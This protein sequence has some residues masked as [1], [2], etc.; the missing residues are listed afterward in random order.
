VD[1]S[2]TRSSITIGTD[3][4]PVISYNGPVGLTVAHCADTAC[5]AGNTLTSLDSSNSFAI[6][7]TIG[8]D[9]MP[10][11]SY[12]TNPVGSRNL[13]VAHCGNVACSSSG[14]TKTMVDSASMLDSTSIAIGTDGLPVIS[15]STG[16]AS[17]GPLQIAHCGS[18]MCIS[19]WV[20]R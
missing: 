17:G 19:D 9:G 7:I 3:G 11:I 13:I 4:L 18:T 14:N 1:T 20:R 6:S 16:E 5:S 10:L 12:E 8:S 15:Y 2:G